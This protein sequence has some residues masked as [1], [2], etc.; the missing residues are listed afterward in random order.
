MFDLN[1]LSTVGQCQH[2]TGQKKPVSIK[3]SKSFFSALS[4]VLT[5]VWIPLILCACGSCWLAVQSN[6]RCFPEVFNTFELLFPVYGKTPWKLQ[7]IPLCY[8]HTHTQINVVILKKLKRFFNFFCRFILQTTCI[9]HAQRERLLISVYACVRDGMARRM[10]QGK[11][12]NLINP[13]FILIP[14][15]RMIYHT[16][17]YLINTVSARTLN[18][19]GRVKKS[20][21]GRDV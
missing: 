20:F 18:Q 19:I 1:K 11:Q 2:A 7:F 9:T 13:N 12:V 4:L 14:K 16:I 21:H 8:T 3:I 17:N 6:Q 15:K 5:L 10:R